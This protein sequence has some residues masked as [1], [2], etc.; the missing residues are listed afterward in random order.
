MGLWK[1]IAVVVVAVGATTLVTGRVVSQDYQKQ[2]EKK[3]GDL[4]KQ[5]EKKIDEHLGGQ[6]NPFDEQ[7]AAWLKSG[8][9]GPAHEEMATWTGTLARPSFCAMPFE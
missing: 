4:R 1:N 3:T 2:L 5:A 8:E 7:M 6:D 9:P